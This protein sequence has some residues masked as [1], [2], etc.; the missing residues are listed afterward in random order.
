MVCADSPLKLVAA[1]VDRVE[2]KTRTLDLFASGSRGPTGHGMA[3][4]CRSHRRS[5]VLTILMP[6]RMTGAMYRL[7]DHNGI[8]QAPDAIAIYLFPERR[9]DYQG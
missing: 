7:V 8:Y 5:A 6:G 1:L 3:V 2:E 9:L 4:P